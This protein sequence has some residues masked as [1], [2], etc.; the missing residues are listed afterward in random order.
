MKY[1]TFIL[2]LAATLGTGLAAESTFGQTLVVN[3]NVQQTRE[4]GGCVKAMIFYNGQ[5]T[6]LESYNSFLTGSAA[7]TPPSGFTVTRT[8]VGRYTIDFGFKVNDRFFSL[9]TSAASGGPQPSPRSANIYAYGGNGGNSISV[10]TNFAVYPGD[11]VDSAFWII[12]Y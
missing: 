1:Y 10:S 2:F 7:N 8:D 12:V 9:T 5:G 3:G 11:F 4:N 6:I